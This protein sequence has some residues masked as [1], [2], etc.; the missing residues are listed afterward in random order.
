MQGVISSIPRDKIFL[1]FIVSLMEKIFACHII[2]INIL[3]FVM[4]QKQFSENLAVFK[5]FLS[6]ELDLLILQLI[7]IPSL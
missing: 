6:N 1:L 2:D 5:L 4:P 3:L 7:F